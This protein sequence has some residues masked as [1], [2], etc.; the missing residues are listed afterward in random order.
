M[1]IGRLLGAIASFGIC[2][3]LGRGTMRAY[4]AVGMSGDT[5][6]DSLLR[7]MAAAPFGLLALWVFILALGVMRPPIDRGPWEPSRFHEKSPEQG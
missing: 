7:L 4:S 5:G 6:G 1:R 3:A 2:L